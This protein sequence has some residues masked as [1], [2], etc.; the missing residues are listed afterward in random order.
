MTGEQLRQAL[1]LYFVMGSPNCEAAIDGGITM[2]QFRE[3]GA[4]AL[5]GQAKLEL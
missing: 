2:F 4:G 1:L 5:Q 3:K